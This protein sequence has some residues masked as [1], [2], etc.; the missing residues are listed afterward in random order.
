MSAIG[1]IRKSVQVTEEFCAVQM[2]VEVMR[3]VS[4]R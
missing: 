2:R 4:A 3:E 1:V